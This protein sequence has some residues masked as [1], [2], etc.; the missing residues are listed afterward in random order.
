[1][2]DKLILKMNGENNLFRGRLRITK[3]AG[4]EEIWISAFEDLVS[5]GTIILDNK[6]KLRDEELEDF[7]KLYGMGSVAHNTLNA[8]SNRQIAV[9]MLTKLIKSNIDRYAFL[10]DMSK[11][12]VL[13]KMQEE[14]RKIYSVSTIGKNNSVNATVVG[15]ELSLP[16]LAV[17][18]KS[19]TPIK[20]DTKIVDYH[21]L[22]VPSTASIAIRPAVNDERT[23]LRV[24]SRRRIEEESQIKFYIESALVEAYKNLETFERYFGIIKNVTNMSDITRTREPN[25]R[26]EKIRAMKEHLDK[27]EAYYSK[28]VKLYG[29]YYNLIR[30]I[31]KCEETATLE[32]FINLKILVNI[33]RKISVALK[34]AAGAPIGSIK[35]DARDI[36]ISE[37]KQRRLKIRDAINEYNE[38]LAKFIKEDEKEQGRGFNLG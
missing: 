7:I 24:L 35:V 5:L 28:T 32:E 14:K 33:V 13:A 15:K 17:T 25:L 10:L 11:E 12:E 3:D 9:D 37:Y 16:P 38:Q 27:L 8:L 31:E 20:V 2:R 22:P 23:Q 19:T 1:M 4:Q 36:T 18:E 26:N 6:D 34:T 30:A 29:D 21:A